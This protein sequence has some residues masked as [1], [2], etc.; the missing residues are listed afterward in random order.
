MCAAVGASYAG[1]IGVTSS[2]GPGIALKMEGIGLAAATELP[3]V[4]I[5]TQR[6]GPSTGM[7]TKT[8]QSDLYQAVFGRNADCPVVVLAARSPADCFDAAIE[9]VRLAVKYMTPVMLL[10]DGYIANASEPWALPDANGFARFPVHHHTETAGYHPFQRDPET[11]ARPWAIPGT[12]GLEHRIGGL[13]R[14]YDTGNVSY[15]P[16]NHQRMTDARAAK[17]DGIARE[18]PPQDRGAWQRSRSH[19]PWSAGARPTG[20]STG[21]SATC[22]TRA[23]TWPIF[24]CAT[25]G[26][27]RQISE[28]F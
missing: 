27:C 25:S 20:R 19:W 8:E 7:P 9:A 24:T 1:S 18:F 5:N 15:D 23:W 28:I 2:S 10:S 12:P 4:V 14:D 16:D 21:R 3:L 11:L 22:A 26:R 6:A 17:I 13:E